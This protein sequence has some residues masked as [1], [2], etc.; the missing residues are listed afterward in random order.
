MTDTITIND[1][2]KGQAPSNIDHGI[3]FTHNANNWSF[4][5]IP[6]FQIIKKNSLNIL[7]PKYI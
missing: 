2:E 1:R 7:S 4:D 5:F 3:N 6:E